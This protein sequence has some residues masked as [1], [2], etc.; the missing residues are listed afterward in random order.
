MNATIKN[1]HFLDLEKTRVRFTLVQ[2]NGTTS[3]AELTVPKDQARGVNTHWDYILDHFD[4]AEMKKKRNEEEIRRRKAV[5]VEDKKRKAH[6][7]NIRLKNLFI[8]KMKSFDLPYIKEAPEDIKSAI[9][10]APDIDILNLI[11]STYTLQ[12]I[13]E[14]EM[15]FV[16]YLDYLDDVEDEIAEKKELK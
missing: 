3:V 4:I 10:R 14:K 8:K 6:E 1:P 11:L 7:E 9:R 5:E 2:E 16:D 13:K 15:T 12:F